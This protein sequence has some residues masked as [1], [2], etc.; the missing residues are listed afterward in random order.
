MRGQIIKRSKDSWT[1]IAE[2]GKDP[3]TGKRK[4]HWQSVKGTKKQAEK[5]LSAL[6][7]HIESGGYVK[8][9]K[10][11]LGKYLE[12][13]LRDYVT[14]NTTPRTNDRYTQIVRTHL[15]PALGSIQLTA[16]QPHHIQSYYG[17]A[18]QSGHRKKESG[19]SPQTIQYHHRVL[20][21]A[22]KHAV[23]RG[24]LLRNPAE[25]VDPPK[26]QRREM[27]SIGPENVNKF[28]EATQDSPYYPIFYTA[29]YTGL[30][31]GELLG[32]RWSDIDLDLGMMSIVQ[33]LQQLRNGE[34]F[35]K[36]PKS[37]HGRRQIALS[38]SLCILLREYRQ[39]QE[40]LYLFAG[41]ALKPS[42]LV[43]SHP[44]GSPMRPN[45]VTRASKRV[46]A[47]IGLDNIRFHDLR[48]AHATLMLRQGIHPKIV[49]ERLG[50]SSIN[51]TLD[52]Y[53]HVLPGLQEAAALRVEEGLQT[54]SE[55]GVGENVG[56]QNGCKT[57]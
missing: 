2:L 42:D 45:S 7:V 38:P 47:S 44:D 57:G 21:E 26:A 48:H 39:N 33:T 55:N 54:A 12:S 34:F 52:I 49:S 11:T 8:P 6:I 4:R 19:L 30:R 43:F 3:T 1:I 29:V 16:I 24:I 20:Y 28:L 9:T 32:L 53:S 10:M 18:L 15:I 5:E 40:G 14:P 27:P 31:R 17:K 50:H 13:W 36:E 41:E 37:R 25:A 46:M 23:K 35:F 51:I 56:L 22:L